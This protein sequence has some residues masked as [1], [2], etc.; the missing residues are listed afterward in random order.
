MKKKIFAATVF[1]VVPIIAV[2]GI[3][4]GFGKIKI[5]GTN[6][7]VLEKTIIKNDHCL[8][9]EEENI[10]FTVRCSKTLWGRINVGDTVRLIRIIEPSGLLIVRVQGDESHGRE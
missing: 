3:F 8:V 4:V 1:V 2:L 10:P 6:V 9:V 7:V 5:P